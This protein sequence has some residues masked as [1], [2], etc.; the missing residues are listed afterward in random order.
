[1]GRTYSKIS[2]GGAPAAFQALDN[3]HTHHSSREI[4]KTVITTWCSSDAWEG[5]QLS[6]D[7]LFISQSV[8]IHCQIAKRGCSGLS[9]KILTFRVQIFF[10]GPSTQR[11]FHVSTTNNK[12]DPIPDIPFALYNKL[13]A[14]CDALFD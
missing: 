8:G 9:G 2:S 4:Q 13:S 14:E 7:T 10:E 12:E 6:L 3:D 1:M 11:G 5:Q